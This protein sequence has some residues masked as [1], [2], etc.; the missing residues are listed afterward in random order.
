MIK[1]QIIHPYITHKDDVC[2]GRSIIDGTRITVW[3]IINWYKKGLCI[4]EI[5]QEYTQ[6]T[7][8]QIHD[9]FSYYYDNQSEIEND[10]LENEELFNDKTLS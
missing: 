9:A 4:E 7:P 10:I 2:G 1:G 8:A 5:I 6:L 3:V